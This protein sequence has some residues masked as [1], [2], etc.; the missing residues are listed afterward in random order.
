[1]FKYLKKK[2]KKQII[3]QKKIKKE[4]SL[5]DLAYLYLESP[6]ITE[7]STFLA[8]KNQYVFKVKPNSNKIQIKS[9]IESLYKINV[10][11]VN[12]INI[13][14]KKKR[15]GRIPGKKGGHKK[16]VVKIK[17]GQKIEFL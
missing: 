4:E 9:A 16:A 6:H 14:A 12:I 5:V 15:I 2:N 8:E 7:K 10:L 17:S 1:M 3:K 13:H 11:N